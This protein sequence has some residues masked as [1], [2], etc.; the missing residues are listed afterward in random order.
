MRTVERIE[1]LAVHGS[2]TIGPVRL[3]TPTVL[4]A[5]GPLE[6]GGEPSV[7]VEPAP[8]GTRRLVI[9]DG[10]HRSEIDVPVLAPE[11]T[12]VG[13]GVFPL[14]RG[15]VLVHAPLD[16]GAL[17]ALRDARPELLLLGNAR[18][19][20]D[21]GE[22]LIAAVRSLR[23]EVGA[24]PLLW[25]TRVALPNRLP[26]LAYLGIDLVDT[27]EGELRAA[28]GEFLDPVLGPRPALS[29]NGERGCDCPSCSAS[30]QGS[31]AAHARA[32]YRRA[33]ME[34][35]AAMG[36]AALRELVESR[37]TSEPVLAELLRYADRDLGPLLEARSPVTSTGT[38]TY[39]LSDAL[40]RP[41]MR[42]FRDR[43]VERY[44]PPPSKTVLLL[45]PCSRTKPYRRS[46]SHRRFATAWDGL[47]GAGR[48]HV[49]S[50][51]SPIGI[52]PRELEDVPPARH[53]DIPV[54]GEWTHEE[55][56]IVIR[57]V[58]H[59]LETGKYRHIV[60][61]LDPEEYGFLFDV[62]PADLG[63]PATVVDGRP[64]SSASVDRLHAVLGECLDGAP[65]SFRGPLALVSEELHEVA[66]VQFGRSAADL[67]FA[68]PLRLE[69]RPWFQRLTDGRH[70]LASLR[71]ER[72]LFHLTV[73]GALRLGDALARVDVDPRLTLEG[74]LFAPG[75]VRADPSVRGG[76]S[77]GLFQDGRLAA[78]G[79]AVLPG[80]LMGDLRRGLAVRVR[81]RRHGPADSAKTAEAPP[82][83]GR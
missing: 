57:G 14:E 3:T 61:H 62:L 43:L 9:G 5:R 53:Y 72:G 25:A 76:D 18:A 79:E 35:D 36:R 40:R 1:G 12:S 17:R 69:G 58:R 23:M 80:P 31:L 83:S 82:P 29:A 27:T 37:I 6:A 7:T 50:V 67:L 73:A 77:V 52:V 65:P 59:L 13:T 20:W 66:S 48:I 34:L 10:V 60:A 70:D 2:A 4:E 42:R 16:S 32:A 15:V 56:E 44:R 38:H 55:R 8:T 11:V 68:H 30:P 26:L 64:T 75:V 33:S 47:P 49:A 24:E 51:S 22:P 28:A 46:P 39:V 81:H 78:V 21:E 19:L 71:E 54:T 74:D 63:R 45:A 41:E